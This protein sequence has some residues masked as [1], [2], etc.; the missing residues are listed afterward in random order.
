MRKLRYWRVETTHI[1]G[2][3]A[4][5]QFIETED[6]RLWKAEAEAL[7]IAKSKSRLADFPQWSFSAIQLDRIKLNG[8]WYTP[9]EIKL[10]R[11]DWN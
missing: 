5:S 4:P 10:K 11:K 2:Y 7:K 3:T 1:N 9:H 6:D 8:K